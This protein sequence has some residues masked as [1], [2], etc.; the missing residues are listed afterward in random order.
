MNRKGSILVVDDEEG[1]RQI[2]GEILKF[3]GYN[4]TLANDGYEAIEKV[5]T[6]VFDIILLDIMMPGMNGL[7]TFLKVKNICPQTVVILMTAYAAEILIKEAIKEGV[8]D[9]IY[10]P[11]SIAVIIGVVERALK[12][13]LLSGKHLKYPLQI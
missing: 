5:K 7:E 9:V 4:T 1:V 8:F 11:F 2:T 13:S 10:K 3:E 12:K 6:T